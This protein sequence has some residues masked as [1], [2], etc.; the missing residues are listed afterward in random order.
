MKILFY[1]MCGT[2]CI[3]NLLLSGCSV[4]H[5]AMAARF[6][7]RRNSDSAS[8]QA[9]LVVNSKTDWSDRQKAISYYICGMIFKEQG[10][11]KQAVCAFDKAISLEYF[12]LDA[13]WQCA[14]CY[15]LQDQP[16]LAQKEYQK[17]QSVAVEL[18]KQLSLSRQDSFAIFDD[19]HWQYIIKQNLVPNFYSEYSRNNDYSKAKLLE[20]IDFLLNEVSQVVE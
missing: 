7:D 14:E 17:L 4:D 5:L 19:P 12:F 8:F 9:K 18:K 15:K 6:Y 2:G 20:R 1:L 13:Y 3:L 10:N 11:L 16:A